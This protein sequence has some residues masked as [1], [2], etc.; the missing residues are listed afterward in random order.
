MILKDCRIYLC[1]PM[2]FSQ[3]MGEGWRKELTPH[4]ESLG[5][6]V[7]DPTNRKTKLSF[8][9]SAS[10][11]HHKLKIVRE[12]QNYQKLT[13]HAKEIVKS[14]LSLVDRSDIILVYI[15]ITQYSVGTIDEFV[16]ACNA[17]KPI[18]LVCKQG[19]KHIPIWFFGR[20]N[21]RYM[22]DSLKESLTY[23]EKINKMPYEEFQE[24]TKE[25]KRWTTITYR[26]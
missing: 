25:N 14:D 22:F 8:S 3:D 21:H 17:R 6:N 20:M 24:F 11:E 18:I 10:E 1:G 7:I 12:A 13:E 9:E 5:L 4:L 16:T 19:K 26:I 15:D 2:E 23:L